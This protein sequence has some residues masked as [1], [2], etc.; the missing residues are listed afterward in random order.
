[1][2]P[3]A[4]ALLGTGQVRAEQMQS[5]GKA[6][7]PGAREALAEPGCSVSEE[8]ALAGSGVG[9]SWA[10]GNRRRRWGLFGLEGRTG[11]G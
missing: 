6:C 2:A 11:G 9:L 3:W 5:R 8:R 10:E 4:S 7:I 1:M